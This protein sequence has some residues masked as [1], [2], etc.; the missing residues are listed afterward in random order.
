MPKTVRTMSE[1]GLVSLDWIAS[2]IT[3]WR[4]QA[5]YFLNFAKFVWRPYV[6]CSF[7]CFLKVGKERE[8]EGEGLSEKIECKVIFLTQLFICLLCFCWF[9]FMV[10][11]CFIIFLMSE[12]GHLFIVNVYDFFMA[13]KL[14][15]TCFSILCF[16][17]EKK[18]HFKR[19][20]KR[21]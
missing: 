3:L 7:W 6:M 8:N 5:R 17:K 2:S 4:G 16:R 18:W 20:N 21:R 11:V 12:M 10:C 14:F 1:L 13:S 9:W 19:Q 15:A